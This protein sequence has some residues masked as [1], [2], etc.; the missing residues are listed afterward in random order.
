M[1]NRIKDIESEYRTFI[2]MPLEDQSP[3][4]PEDATAAEEQ[5]WIRQI[6]SDEEAQRPA[7]SMAQDS[8][9]ATAKAETLR[10]LANAT[11]SADEYSN[12]VGGTKATK[13][14]ADIISEWMDAG[15]TEAELAA[16][17][18]GSM[19]L[20]EATTKNTAQAIAKMYGLQQKIAKLRADI[21]TTNRETKSEPVSERNIGIGKHKFADRAAGDFD[22][23]MQDRIGRFYEILR[24]V[25]SVNDAKS[26]MN[27]MTLEQSIMAAKDE[28]S[29]LPSAVRTMMAEIILKRIVDYR[30]N[31]KR[32]PDKDAYNKATEMHVDFMDWTN[33]FIKDMGQGV[34]AM[35]RWSDLGP[36][37][38]V[39]K[40]RRDMNKKIAKVKARNKP[41]IKKL[42]GEF[43]D[44]DTE[45]FDSASKVH[46]ERKKKAAEKA[47]KRQARVVSVEEQAQKALDR[48][49]KRMS[50]EKIAKKTN[51]LSEL[52][53]THM[54]KFDPDFAAKAKALGI[55]DETASKLN[56]IATKL[57]ADRKALSD[58]KAIKDANYKAFLEASRE[59]AKENKRLYGPTDTIWEQYQA[60]IAERMAKALQ[61]DP[62]KPIPPNLLIFTNRMVAN[63]MGFV[64]PKQ[65]AAMQPMQMQAVIEDALNNKEKYQEAFEASVR[66]LRGGVGPLTKYHTEFFETLEPLIKDFPV[67]Q[68]TVDRFVNQKS[69]DIDLSLNN[70][71]TEW[72]HGDRK[73]RQSIEEIIAL[74]LTG[75]LNV[76]QAD[77]DKLA[78]MIVEDFQRKAEHRR[79]V[80]IERIKKA[81]TKDEADQQKSKLK[82]FFEVVNMGA[83]TDEDAYTILAEKL[84]L[85]KFDKAFADE[86][87]ED[88]QKIQD[89]DEGIARRLAT[90]DLM[91]KIAKQ[92]GF[93][94]SDFGTSFVYANILSSPDT[95]LVNIVDT[96]INNFSNA[97][98]DYIGS[99]GK[100]FS[101]IKGVIDGYRKGWFES[102]EV[103]KTGKRLSLPELD[104][105][106][107]TILELAEFGK[108]GGVPIDVKNGM[109][110]IVKGLL[111]SKPASFL[112]FAKY[113]GRFLEAQ[114]A[115]NLAASAEGQR[116]SDAAQQAREEGLTDKDAIRKR[117][118]EILNSSD[119]AYQDALAKAKGEGYTGSEAIYRAIEITEEAIPEN[120][121]DRAR[122]RGLKDVYRSPMV[123]YAGYLASQFQSTLAKIQNPLVRN[124]S[125]LVVSPFV[126]TP[127][128]LFNKWLD[129]TPYGY[130]RAFFGSG[131]GLPERFQVEPSP[132]DSTE[133]RTQIV[134]A[135]S[136]I[137]V[138]A[139]V[140]GLIKAGVATIEGMGPSDDEERKQ[141]QADGNK[142]YSIRFGNGPA[143][144]FQF[145][146]WALM[147]AARANYSDWDKYKK[148]SEKDGLVRF[149]AAIGMVPAFVMELP[150]FSGTADLFGLLT[151]GSRGQGANAFPKFLEG[152]AGMLFPNFLRYV[153]RLFDPTRYKTEEI[154]GIIINQTPFLRRT[155]GQVLDMFGDPIGEGKPLIER[156]A[157]RFV[158]FPK[159]TEASTIL[160]TF[161]PS[162]TIDAP[163]KAYT[164]EGNE[165]V[166]MSQEQYE[167]FAI[168]IG[169]EFKE[170]LTKNYDTQSEYDAKQLEQGKRRIENKHQQLRDKW[171]RKV[172]SK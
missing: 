66:E 37:G 86:V 130:K 143:I 73:T 57:Q 62:D 47:G 112:S 40:L 70:A 100:D 91:A 59:L 41:K 61:A 164:V 145:S 83:L 11:K 44:A 113:V 72:Y 54:R 125:K 30:R 14:M 148:G 160:A 107:P 77:A 163:N 76:P 169:Q 45:A 84:K 78:T 102:V 79:L 3:Q 63:L 138:L 144:S 25:D 33:D 71:F 149:A 119:E 60:T 82:R 31:L 13:P 19:N 111:E 127:T 15:G 121:K 58:A 150:F 118:Q 39:M 134:K 147:M 137:L 159:P 139:V 23:D 136:S 104:E 105:K 56:D 166:P 153:D 26:I 158:S 129:W 157:G 18:A 16:S 167:K 156:L 128:N 43:E 172:A 5:D 85:P 133:F 99:G 93:A 4:L 109:D 53:N 90:R 1:F 142:P 131:R 69:K 32:E 161:E 65:G 29:G 50:G 171:R 52:I 68:Q 152:K 170:F 120:I 36:D 80:A 24:N 94:P 168:G 12:S 42:K 48:I 122:E 110:A 106:A 10:K 35:A 96:L 141:W 7:P 117:M 162:L 154:Q 67:S 49:I 116:Y 114:D 135:S 124:V 55:S 151:A 8:E 132:K 28:N 64:E 108:K 115:A 38:I 81:A 98:A 140:E 155:G 123:G 92:K 46:G 89:M 20:T 51:P 21:A 97:I 88:A 101:R 103:L 9:Q 22:Q 74:K 146:P 27:S 2:D 6:S 95:H 34:Q 165:R 17:L 126:V 87:Y 75:D